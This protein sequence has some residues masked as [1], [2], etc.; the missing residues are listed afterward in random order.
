MK[1]SVIIALALSAAAPAVL[2]AQTISG[3]LTLSYTRQDLEGSDVN[4]RGLDGRMETD[5]GNGFTFGLEVGVSKMSADG[6]SVDI[7]GEFFAL[8]GGYRFGN[9]IK[10][11]LFADRLTLGLGGSLDLTLKTNGLSFGY[12]KDGIEVE[13]FVANTSLSLPLPFEIDNQGISAKYSGVEGLEVG[14]AFLRAKLSTGGASEDIDFK[15]IAASYVVGESFLLFG[16]VSRTDIFGLGDL[17]T[18]GLGVGYDLSGMAGF[19]STV[20]LELAQTD[21]GDGEIDT[22]RLGVSFPLG[23][24][25][26]MVPL[27]SVAD[28]VLNPRHGALN[29]ALTSAF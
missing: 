26:P 10:A 9:G 7:D 5:F 25:G 14:G 15:G 8:D 4:T 6:S 23:K 12:E 11:G 22:V 24:K 17:D 27:N 18:V 13:A 3:G 19:A 20:S 16:G 1:R 2:E 29:A 28:S 21:L